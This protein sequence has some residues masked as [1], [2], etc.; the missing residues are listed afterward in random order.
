MN[1]EIRVVTSIQKPSATA[2]G[3][4]VDR[5]RTIIQ[6]SHLNFLIGAGT[7]SPY[8]ESLGNIEKALTKIGQSK[9]K[10]SEKSFARTS[11]Q[12]Y[13]FEKV[14]APNLGIL[15]RDAAAKELIKSYA[16]FAIILNRV[17][18]QRRSTLLGK[19]ANIFTSNVDMAFE[20][21]FELLEIDVNDGFAGKINPRLD[22][23]EFNTLRFRQGTRYEYRSEIPV[24]NLF[25]IH[26]SV[27]W[28]R[29]GEEIFYDHQLKQL[30]DVNTAYEAAKSDLQPLNGRNDI[31]STALIL[32]ASGKTLTATGKKFAKAYRELS[33]VNPD[34][35]KFATT[36][37]N[38]TYY[39]LIRRLA[40][41]LEKEN[42]ALLVH[43]FS[44]RDEH[45]CDLVVRAARTNPT[46]QVIVFCYTRADRDE[47][48]TLIPEEQIKNGNILFVAP[49]EPED[50]ED[51]RKLSLDVLVE[52][53]LA[54]ILS[55][56]ATMADNV[57]ELK[58]D[59][60]PGSGSNA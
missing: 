12:G 58:L 50:G 8:F 19:Q 20:V 38:E 42:T 18:L 23:G 16:R 35:E 7:S 17:L 6:D 26:G 1:H 47:I 32:A 30:A 56:Q 11:L 49:N 53:F 2:D 5:L 3:L 44:F 24:V 40:N 43:G 27:G 21:S 9:K 45:L 41:E 14:L 28:R 34:K 13:F 46:L 10:T 25:K 60:V 51:E 37:L 57:I 55:E 59:G 54:P 22:L 4:S 39:E 48:S 52:D 15:R 29:E 36:V 33:I 31:D